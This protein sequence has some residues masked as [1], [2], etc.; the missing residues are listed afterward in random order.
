MD[1]IVID[2][3]NLGYQRYIG[4]RVGVICR[5]STYQVTYGS[6]RNVYQA[7]RISQIKPIILTVWLAEM[8]VKLVVTISILKLSCYR[9][10]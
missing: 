9:Y 5:C 8:K 3:Y 6:D 7:V 1:C 4:T 10:K 2:L